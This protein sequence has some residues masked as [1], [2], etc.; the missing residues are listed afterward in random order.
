MSKSWNGGK[1]SRGDKEFSKIQKLAHENKK[2]KT[3]IS[4]IRK[5]LNRLESGW[6][7]GCLD[8]YDSKDEKMTLPEPCLTKPVGKDR[9]CF[10]CKEGKLRMVKYYKIA[11]TWYYRKCDSCPHRTR[12]KKFTPD[13]QD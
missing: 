6:C 12:G 7:P 4:R 5:N 8:R 9:T 2:L 10:K 1:G 3:E 11:E 13:V